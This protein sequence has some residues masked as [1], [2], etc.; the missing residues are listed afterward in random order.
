MR[1]TASAPACRRARVDESRVTLSRDLAKAASP[2]SE[3]PPGS[4]FTLQA[5]FHQACD[6]RAVHF[7]A[8]GLAREQDRDDLLALAE[9]ELLVHGHPESVFADVAGEPLH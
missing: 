1:R 3:S 4:S 2:A 5:R 6:L 7:V 8:V 9:H